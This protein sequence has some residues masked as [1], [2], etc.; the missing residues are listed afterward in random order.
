[1]RHGWKPSAAVSNM[2]WV[3]QVWLPANWFPDAM[4]SAS[5]F[6]KTKYFFTGT[7]LFFPV[8]PQCE[9]L[10]FF[11]AIFVFKSFRDA[12]KQFRVLIRRPHCCCVAI[13]V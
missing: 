11:N 12:K 3:G 7:E 2:P 8:L 5:N 9:I 4:A 10:Q 1:M 13:S 6:F